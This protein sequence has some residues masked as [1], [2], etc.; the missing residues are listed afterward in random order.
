MQNIDVKCC[1]CLF[2]ETFI[3]DLDKAETEKLL[4]NSVRSNSYG[5]SS[6]DPNNEKLKENDKTRSD[7]WR[8]PRMLKVSFNAN[9]NLTSSNV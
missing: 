5:S 1:H 6:D 4:L 2:L 8:W 9:S 3:E 7:N